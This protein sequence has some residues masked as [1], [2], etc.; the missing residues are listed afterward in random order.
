M[1]LTPHPWSPGFTWEDHTGPLRSLTTDQAKAFDEDGFFVIEDAFDGATVEQ[2]RAEID[3]L[4]HDLTEWLRSRGGTFSISDADAIT[5]PYKLVIRSA[6]MRAFCSSEALA[7]VA[8]DLIGPDVLLYWEQ[9]VYKKPEPVRKF[10]WH[11]DNGYAFLLPEPYLTC[12]IP[13]VDVT[14]E[15]GCPWLAPGYHRRGT[16]LHHDSPLGRQVFDDPAE[17]VPVEARAGSIVV[18]SS[19]TPHFTGP[20]QSDAVRKAYI[21]QY[22]P[23]GA[24]TFAGDPVKTSRPEPVP[25]HDPAS[26]YPVLVGGER[27]DPPPFSIVPRGTTWHAG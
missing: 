21:V 3:P 19:L 14:V 10:P 16:F 27:V 18:F 2:L 25:V 7:G 17:A 5:F 15:N 9:A 23:A 20:N 24:R 1:E 22:V 11:Q 8:R 6:W 12:W 26:Q 4:E 13:L